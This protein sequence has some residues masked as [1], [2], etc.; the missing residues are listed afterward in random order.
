M[1]HMTT[2]HNPAELVR[3]PEDNPFGIGPK[4]EIVV[5]KDIRTLHGNVQ[6]PA[7]RYEAQASEDH[8][9]RGH[10]SKN[11]VVIVWSANGYLDGCWTSIAY[12]DWT[13][14]GEALRP[15]PEHDCNDSSHWRS[16]VAGG[17]FCGVCKKE[18][19]L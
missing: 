3:M 5:R 15:L 1:G 7:G 19:D 16:G 12:E 18:I 2:T 10:P 4:F 11:G 9:S 17:I 14:P 8:D 13:Y 6:V